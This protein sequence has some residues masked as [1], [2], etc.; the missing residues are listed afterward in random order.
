MAARSSPL[1][2]G[3][4]MIP[5]R[6]WYY[7]EG[8]EMS[9]LRRAC[10]DSFKTWN[11]EFDVLPMQRPE[12]SGLEGDS[13]WARILRSDWSRWQYLFRYGG[14]YFDTDIIFTEPI[15]ARWLEKD[16]LLPIQN[17]ALYG[18]HFLGAAQHSTFFAAMIDRSRA[19]LSSKLLP[20]CQSLG[21][22][23]L[24]G[25]NVYEILNRLGVDSAA[26][27]LEAFLKVGWNEV[28][29]LWSDQ[30]YDSKGSIGLHWYGG[31]P[32]SQHFEA[33][34]LASLPDCMVKY[35]LMVSASGRV[36]L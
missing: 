1:R 16:L 28:E 32:M 10:V 3:P 12:E 25:Q 9:D 36:F 33:S 18:V 13:L 26:V 17:G 30:V 20:G 19:R 11:P 7:W 14:I 21:V 6:A 2:S 29:R 5:K 35:A 23:L 22:K 4:S 24:E 8:E 15:P 34:P 31:D 27:P